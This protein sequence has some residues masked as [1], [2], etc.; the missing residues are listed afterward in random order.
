MRSKDKG[1]CGVLLHIS[2]LPSK[3]GI[4]TFGAEACRFADF[5]SETGQKYWQILPLVPLG[6]GNSPY[7]SSSCFAGEI[8]YIDLD[9]LVDD[10]LLEAQ[11][12]EWEESYGRVDYNETRKFKIPLLILAASRFDITDHDYKTFLKQNAFWLEDYAVYACMQAEFGEHFYRLP[13]ELRLRFPVALEN[14]R[15]TRADE[16]RIYKVTQ[17]LFY[18]QYLSLKKYCNKRGVSII[19]DIPFYISLESAEVWQNPDNFRLGRDFT[20]VS[21]A[22]VPPDRFSDTGQLWGNPIYDWDY[23]KK[24]GFSFWKK[25][26]KFCSK[27]YDAL[28]ID[29]F[30]AFASFYTIPYGAPDAKNGAWEHGPGAGFWRAVEKDCG[31]LLII[32]EDLGGEEPDVEKLLSEVGFPNMKVLQFGFDGDMQNRFLPRNYNRNC[33]CYT[34]THD[35][36]TVLG[37]YENAGVKER[38]FF[39]SA[40]SSKETEISLKMIDCAMK[41][42]AGLVIIPM[43]DWLC[44]G[45]DARMNTPATVIKNW[46]WRMSRDIDYESLKE[47][48]LRI[49]KGRI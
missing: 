5:L 43:Q 40:I 36:D 20:P 48:F 37:W 25:R 21:V 47:T 23:H 16:L 8:L 42:R 14:Y 9:L 7:K 29:H 46:E 30:R 45:E 33:V 15:R 39:E 18:K 13:E 35:N 10:G 19:G 44:L 24:T 3:H 6:D 38:V 49:C 26:L 2:S 31:D 32:A 4:G 22:G 17:Y 41:S 1:D 34:G 11:E 28:R 27:L 12:I